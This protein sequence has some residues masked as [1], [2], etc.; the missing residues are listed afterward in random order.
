[1]SASLTA[2]PACAEIERRA[3]G[4]EPPGHT[5]HLGP[6]PSGAPPSLV[7]LTAG[8]SPLCWC[9]PAASPCCVPF[10]PL[11]GPGDSQE[12]DRTA[13]RVQPNASSSLL[14]VALGL[15]TRRTALNQ[16]KPHRFPRNQ[17][18]LLSL[19]FAGVSFRSVRTDLASSF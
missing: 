11:L 6:H 8:P 12:S 15:E 9:P 13:L 16:N 18:F 1:M 3:Q 7:E 10:P 2:P 17:T 4:E 5:K 14:T 19:G